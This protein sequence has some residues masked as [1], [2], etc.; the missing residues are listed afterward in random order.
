M[1]KELTIV[2]ITYKRYPFLK[3]LLEFFFSYQSDAQFLIL[4]SSPDY[5]DDYELKDLLV[6]DRVCWQRF[7]SSIFFAEKIA[8]GC[9]YI[10]TDY[11]VLCADDDFL[12]PPALSECVRFL[13]Q[14]SDYASAHGFHFI[15][16]KE[17]IVGRKSL[18][19]SRLYQN[20]RSSEEKTAAER[21]AAYLNGTTGC[22]PLYAVHRTSA[23][24][25][26][27]NETRE[28]VTDWGLSELFPCSLSF[29]FGRMKVLSVFY[30]SRE[31]NSLSWT[32]ENRIAEMYSTEKI[33]RS[34]IGIGKHLGR[35]DHTSVESAEKIVRSAFQ[36]YLN[37]VRK[38]RKLNR[39]KWNRSFPKVLSALRQK[40]RIRTFVTSFLYQLFYQGC[41]PSIYPDSLSDYI[42]VK[43]AVLTAGLTADELNKARKDYWTQKKR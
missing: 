15:H 18:C 21:I 22:Y 23:F 37:I 32:D 41:H 39:R 13:S 9:R 1:L 31:P 5:P 12:I 40:L 16:N 2:I 4:D 26:I 38:K 19:L 10:K 14:H 20:G 43:N 29:M 6:S 25:I 36:S 24:C 8:E 42:K 35:V 11:A 34:V 17:N 3:R 7:D 30:S 28:Y 27:W 33:E